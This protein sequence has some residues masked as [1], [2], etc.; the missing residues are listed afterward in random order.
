MV[1]STTFP[2]RVLTAATLS[3]ALAGHAAAQ[4]AWPTRPVRIVAPFAPGGAPDVAIRL[5]LPRLTAA[6]GRAFVVENRPGGNG[7]I[8]AEA[9]ARAAP[10][11]QTL[12]LA[13][14]SVMAVN[15]AL[16]GARLPYDSVRDFRPVSRIARLPFFVFVPANSPARDLPA[17]LAAAGTAREP[18]SYATN[19]V[20]TMGHILTEQL[21]RA[22]GVELVHVPYRGYPAAMSDLL[23]GR[24]MLAL[25]DLTVFGGPLRGGQLRALAAVAPERSRFLPDVPAL[26]ELGLPPLD[27]SVWFGLF[28]PTGTADGIVARLEAELRDW[29]T[30]PETVSGLANISQEPAYLDAATLATTLRE[31]TAR[32]AAIIAAAGIQPE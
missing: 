19:G 30:K 28:A 4:P 22:V 20:G 26:P 9:V 24:V 6:F 31:E 25:A 1:S 18:L 2:R 11:G 27:G 16:Y 32:Y 23:S 5:A 12:L 13:S 17:L 14:N 21:R 10:D 7:A 29:L 3:A 8:A 15:P